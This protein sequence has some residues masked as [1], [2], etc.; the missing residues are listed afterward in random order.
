MRKDMKEKA[1]DSIR[2]GFLCLEFYGFHVEI[3]S[4]ESLLR[5]V[6]RDYSYFL[7]E[8]TEPDLSIKVI[9]EK[10]AYTELPPLRSCFVT[11]R[12]VVYR[13][14][15]LSY[16]D[17]FGQALSILDEKRGY[18]EV[19]CRNS[20]LGHEICF[21]TILSAVGSYLDK[22]NI[23]RIH[24]LGMAYHGKSVL[25]TLPTGGG[26][27]TL[28]LRLLQEK[29]FQL[30]SEDSPLVDR[31][32]NVLPFPLRTG[33]K[34]G[35]EHDA[36][37]EFTGRIE[38][39]EFGPKI[40][41]DIEYFSQS[42]GS[43]TPPGLIFMGTRTFGDKCEIEPAPRREL[44]STL[45]KNMVVGMGVYQG[46]EFLFSNRLR[47]LFKKVPVASSRLGNAMALVR[48]SR[49]YHLSLG[50]DREKNASHLID[51]VKKE[52]S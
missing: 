49:G 3:I 37:D 9:P 31:R 52:L 4:D 28:A 47:D 29:D 26:K 45:F 42:I 39:M 32:G 33:V 44:Y 51:F 10:P 19:F 16:I 22:K 24:A 7:G 41:I 35:E 6:Y 43:S 25:I 27:T 13:S 50:Y 21:L 34:E 1:L 5:R 18:C 38:R 17:Y 2:K 46:M 15:T 12:N 14:G 40:V 20:H 36:P 30:L 48:Q 23:H 8:K 11:P